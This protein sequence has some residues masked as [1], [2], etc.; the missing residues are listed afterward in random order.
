MVVGRST[1]RLECH[2]RT[3][4]MDVR[5]YPYRYEEDVLPTAAAF[6]PSGRSH[7]V[8]S[9]PVLLCDTVVD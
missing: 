3:G 8:R 2:D 5:Y 6:S 1:D 7:D 9:D 4:Q